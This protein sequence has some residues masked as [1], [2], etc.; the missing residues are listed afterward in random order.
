MIRRR[1]FENELIKH[2]AGAAIQ[3][4][5]PRMARMGDVCRTSGGGRAGEMYVTAR[6]MLFNPPI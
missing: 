1:A 5:K 2:E 6:A 3:T 4:D